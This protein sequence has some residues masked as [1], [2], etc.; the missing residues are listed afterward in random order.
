MAT[1]TTISV[2]STDDFQGSSIDLKGL[3][4][5]PLANISRSTD[6][7]SFVD[8]WRKQKA[9][10]DIELVKEYKRIAYACSN[11]NANACSQIPVRL[12]VKTGKGDK[13]AR[14]VTRKLS[15][16]QVD[17]LQKSPYLQKQLR[18]LIDVEEVLEHRIL[19]LL[20]KVNDFPGCTGNWLRVNTQ[21]YQEI[22]GKAY[23]YI[24]DDIF[25]VPEQ[26]WIIPS[27]HLTPFREQNS[28]KLI[29][30]Y[31]FNPGGPSEKKYSVEEIIP[32]LM[33]N[34]KNPYVDGLSPL[35]ASW[36][37]NSVSNKL[38]AH[39]DTFLSNEA[40]PDSIITPTK[41]NPLGKDEAKRI[42]ININKKF[43]KGG[44]GRTWV[45]EEE[46]Q[47]TPINYPPRDLARLEIH[48]WS[49]TEICNA[50]DTPLALLEAVNINRATL[51]GARE[52][53]AL[54]C[55]KPRLERVVSNLNEDFLPRFDPSGRLFL[56]YDNPVPE[57]EEIKLQ[58]WAQLVMNGIATPNE[59]RDDYKLPPLPGGD[60]LVPINV[61]PEVMRQ[62][63]RD[64]GSAKQ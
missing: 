49:K 29:D 2:I 64:S 47:F 27:Q 50:Y 44:A 1:L 58:K 35:M 59:A 53:H 30:Y 61:S 41:D 48:K 26:I 36:E 40:R 55:V 16:K 34:L 51:E 28:N 46:L 63:E 7:G 14:C 37:A 6:Y 33:P 57:I 15:T 25:G 38:I 45:S 10:D 12:Y 9:P 43:G 22:V 23:W 52:Q 21:L 54:N 32:F 3:N 60:K 4:P 56:A 20:D 8:I 11:L 18:E 19:D 24:V 39:E 62:N 42:E 31:K 17:N 5:T 13:K